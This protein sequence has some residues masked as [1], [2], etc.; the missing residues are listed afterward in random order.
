MPFL[1]LVGYVV[2]LA[3]INARLTCN[4]KYVNFEIYTQGENGARL[5][6]VVIDA[7]LVLV[8]IIACRRDY[9]LDL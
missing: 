3:A 5:L 8:Y 2:L 4:L 7:Y 1:V 9:N 6:V